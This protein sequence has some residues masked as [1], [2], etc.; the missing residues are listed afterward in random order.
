M[1]HVNFGGDTTQPI[2]EGIHCNGQG[3][4]YSP[5]EGQR[6]RE[7]YRQGAGG[8]LCAGH[9]WVLGTVDTRL[10]SFTCFPGKLG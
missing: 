5:T 7:V 1:Q 9:T 10:R 2:T 4:K 6:G 8:I 3:G